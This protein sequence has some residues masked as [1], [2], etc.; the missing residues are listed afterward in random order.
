MIVDNA[1]TVPVLA[2][3][4]APP[5]PRI[6]HEPQLGLTA[7]RRRGFLEA[8]GEIIVMV[9]DDNVLAPDYLAR[10]SDFFATHPQVGALGGR[11]VPE[12]ESIPPAWVR[13]F[14]GLLA[15]RDLGATRLVSQ[16]LRSPTTGRNEYPACA[17]IGAGMALRRAAVQTW[18]DQ[19]TSA[20]PSD[21]RGGELTSGGDNDIVFTLMRHGWEVAYDPSLSL[22]HLIPSARLTRDYLARLNRG[23]AKSWMQVLRRHEA[24]PWPCIARWTVPLRQLKAWFTHRAWAGPAQFVRWQGACGHFE[25]RVATRP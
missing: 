23:I 6:I 24:N 14:D 9:D 25:G 11:S 17:P 3:S 12:F 8:T 16:G 2:G 13:E 18:L 22:T 4:D 20:A 21:R 10:V 5:N 1:S 19:L 15:C 7:A